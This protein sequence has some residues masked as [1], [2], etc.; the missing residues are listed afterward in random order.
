MENN[1]AKYLKLMK[2]TSELNSLENRVDCNRFKNLKVNFGDKDDLKNLYINTYE[3][4]D[5]DRIDYSNIIRNE[6]FNC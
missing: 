2:M 3:N 6:D 4:L 1:L 5:D